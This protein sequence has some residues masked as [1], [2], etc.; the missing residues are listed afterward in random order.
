LLLPGEGAVFIDWMEIIGALLVLDM[1]AQ[2]I[3]HVV[4][5]HDIAVHVFSAVPTVKSSYVV[6]LR[7]KLLASGTLL[8]VKYS[9][10]PTTK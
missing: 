2:N 1:A 5:G 10:T 8:L 9:F 3:A 6:R 4:C 7:D